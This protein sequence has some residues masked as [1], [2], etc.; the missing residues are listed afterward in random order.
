MYP[1][2]KFK[3]FGEWESEVDA[4]TRRL[5]EAGVPPWQAAGQA[6]K[7]V[8]RNRRKRATDEH[9]GNMVENFKKELSGGRE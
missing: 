5:V 4:E 9:M 1:F 3:V 7:N 8:Q 6:A 2:S